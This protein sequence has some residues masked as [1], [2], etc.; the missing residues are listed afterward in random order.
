MDKKT[1]GLI[2]AVGAGAIAIYYFLNKNKTSSSS[3]T[4]S[5]PAQPTVMP[6]IVT[7][8]VISQPQPN[9]TLVY[10]PAQIY[11]PITTTT[12][13]NIGNGGATPSKPVATITPQQQQIVK[14]LINSKL[15]AA[16]PAFRV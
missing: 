11:N 10:A 4:T 5:T 12:I 13:T 3:D 1:I 6:V 7:P 8:T 14:G 15:G 2:L 9:E 16:A